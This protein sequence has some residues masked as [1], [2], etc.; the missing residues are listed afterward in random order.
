MVQSTTRLVL[1]FAALLALGVLS[2]C[3]LPPLTPTPLPTATFRIVPPSPTVNP[4]LPT[5]P[6][7]DSPSRILG[8][9]AAI[10][11][12]AAPPL[13]GGAT[14]TPLPAPTDPFLSLQFTLNDGLPITALYF[15]SARRGAPLA[16]IIPEEGARK[17]D[18]RLLAA[19][20]QTSGV[21]VLAVDVRN[22]GVNVRPDQLVDDLN[23]ILTRFTN[24]ASVDTTRISLIGAGIGANLAA[25][26]CASLETCRALVLISPN[27]DS[28]GFP[29]AGQVTAYG[30]RPLLIAAGRD[31]PRGG[32]GAITLQ[33]AV[34]GAPTVLLYETRARGVNLIE[35]SSDLVDQIVRFI[36]AR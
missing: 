4:I 5:Q 35:A 33:D 36:S 8:T 3:D 22:G 21:T 27:P 15:A 16:V 25:T 31:D 28:E 9:Q 26:I 24:L 29:I 13:I 12:P 32:V 11:T 20:L 6:D 7:P 19:S 18:W 1:L 14:V 30:G 10:F 23:A 34:R 17:E 2:G